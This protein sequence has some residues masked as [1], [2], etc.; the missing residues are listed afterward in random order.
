M[1]TNKPQARVPSLESVPEAIRSLYV[2]DEKAG[3]FYLDIDGLDAHPAVAG[4]KTNKEEILTEKKGLEAK[5]AAWTALGKTPEQI[6]EMIANAEAAETAKKIAEGKVDEVLADANTRHQNAIAQLT[7]NHKTAQTEWETK[8]SVMMKNIDRLVRE[9]AI[10]TA[11]GAEK[12]KPSLLR[13]R[14]LNLTETVEV[15]KG[16][17]IVYE[18]RVKDPNTGNHRY[19]DAVGTFMSPLHLVQEMKKDVDNYGGAFEATSPGGSGA[20]SHQTKTAPGGGTAQTASPVSKIS[21]G[22]AALDGK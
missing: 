19:A 10:D 14:L 15:K 20:P 17:E 12:G 5:V 22:L 6:T 16:D 21:A 4:L 18:V 3:D 11:L 8:S 9:N 2:K 7:N 1:P 13:D